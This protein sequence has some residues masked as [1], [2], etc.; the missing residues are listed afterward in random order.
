MSSG[1]KMKE[2]EKN[3]GNIIYLIKEGKFLWPPQEK[4]FHWYMHVLPHSL[5]STSN[6]QLKM[7]LLFK[8][9]TTIYSKS[10]PY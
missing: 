1:G 2:Y 9:K 7:H 6:Q 8:Y 5:D 3:N 10:T 4:R